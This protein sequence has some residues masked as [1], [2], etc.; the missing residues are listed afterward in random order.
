MTVLELYTMALA[1]LNELD[2]D[3]KDYPRLKIPYINLA[4]AQ[5]FTTE[6]WIRRRKGLPLLESIPAV[7]KDSDVLIYDTAYV[8][9]CMV[10]LLAAM[11]ATDEDRDLANVYSNMYTQLTQK[12]LTVFPENITDV[13]KEASA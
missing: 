12:H 5:C 11:L 9:E 4:L 10:Y 1:L 3:T 8:R 13:Y 7:C 6:N 2:T